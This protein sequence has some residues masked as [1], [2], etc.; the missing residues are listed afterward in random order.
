MAGCARI[1]PAVCEVCARD[2]KGLRKASG[3]FVVETRKACGRVPGDA[4][5]IRNGLVEGSRWVRARLPLASRWSVPGFCAVV[6]WPALD[7]CLIG[8]WFLLDS[9]PPRDDGSGVACRISDG[10][11]MP[12]CLACVIDLLDGV[13]IMQAEG[14]A[15]TTV[16]KGGA[17]GRSHAV[18]R[19]RKNDLL[20][21]RDRRQGEVAR[22]IRPGYTQRAYA[23]VFASEKDGALGEGM[24]RGW[25]RAGRQNKREGCRSASPRHASH[26]G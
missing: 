12:F 17:A 16:P 7:S 1:L 8:A 9:C 13:S 21:E 3:R 10:R 5:L 24:G 15:Q 6:V 22:R 4:C 25:N 23:H 18:R 2:A 20:G 11:G 19:S 26:A 14:R